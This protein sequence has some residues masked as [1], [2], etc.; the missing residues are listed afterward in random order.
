MGTSKPAKAIKIVNT[1]TNSIR[2][3]PR[4][5][6]RSADPRPGKK[7][8]QRLLWNKGQDC[9]ASRFSARTRITSLYAEDT[10]ETRSS[11]ECYTFFYFFPSCWVEGSRAR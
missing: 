7:N 11:S 3:K 6:T 5:R 1:T 2:V 4:V 8:H 10:E 9:D